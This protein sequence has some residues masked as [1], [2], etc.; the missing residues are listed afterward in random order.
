MITKKFKSWLLEHLKI[1]LIDNCSAVYKHWSSISVIY[2]AYICMLY[3]FEGKSVP[4]HIL[5]IY[6]EFGI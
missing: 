6:V 4:T 3:S 2:V 5:F 1:Q